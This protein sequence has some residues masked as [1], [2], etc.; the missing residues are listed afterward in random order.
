[1]VRDMELS[2]LLKKAFWR[3]C[4]LV[5]N[6]DRSYR[7]EFSSKLSVDEFIEFAEHCKEFLSQ[8]DI[9]TGA[10][11][12][13]YPEESNKI[14]TIQINKLLAIVNFTEKFGALDKAIQLFEAANDGDAENINRL[15]GEGTNVNAKNIVGET[16]LHLAAR[17]GHDE[18]IDILLEQAASINST[19]NEGETP[20]HIVAQT[21][22]ITTLEKLLATP[23]I[24]V[25]GKDKEGN[26][27]LDIADR[28]SGAEIGKALIDALL[29]Q[30]PKI[31]KPDFIMQ[32]LSDHWDAQT[33]KL[34]DNPVMQ[35]TLE[36]V[37]GGAA[38]ALGA[39]MPQ[40]LR[41]LISFFFPAARI[42]VAHSTEEQ[43]EVKPAAA[44]QTKSQVRR[45]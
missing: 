39:Q 23:G 45:V 14:F 16:S 36:G 29:K 24:D 37:T 33:K 4:S 35:A 12:A 6:F 17:M 5:S 3:E 26:T 41:K 8:F 27:A 38:V 25:C 34:A 2:E 30:D 43:T 31:E 19:N 1:M 18:L 44:I 22:Q 32:A 21:E 9:E 10:I 40:I 20:L 28:E 13:I 42:Q 11:V 15:L 7:I